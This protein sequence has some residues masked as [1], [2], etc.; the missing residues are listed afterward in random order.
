MRHRNIVFFYGAGMLSEDS[1]PFLV[2]EF[3]P[4]GS[5]D[6]VVHRAGQTLTWPQKIQFTTDIANGLDFIHS[7]DRIH[8]DLKCA[9]IL[10]SATWVCKIADFGT[11]KLLGV[12]SNDGTKTSHT[13]SLFLTRGVGRWAG[14]MGGWGG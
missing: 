14:R 2:T 7:H 4:R 12:L 6:N 9:N 1:A 11:S 10:L 8:R 3:F 13:D 5:L